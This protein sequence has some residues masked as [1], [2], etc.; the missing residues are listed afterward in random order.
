M[1]YHLSYAAVIFFRRDY[2]NGPPFCQQRPQYGFRAT[3]PIQ[4]RISA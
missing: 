3:S 4:A 1:L 2:N